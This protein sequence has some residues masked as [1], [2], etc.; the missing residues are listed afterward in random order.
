MTRLPALHLLICPLLHSGHVEEVQ[1]LLESGADPT[2]RD[3][4]GRVP[5]QLA[6]QRAAR[7]AMRRFMSAHP[8]RWDWRAA[9]VPSA[10]T[11]EM[12]AAQAAKQVKE[13]V[14]RPG[15][16]CRGRVEAPK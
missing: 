2:A 8:D 3:E 1:Q 14:M 5:Y 12:E 13:G 7:D 15:W 9:H 16:P 11:E 10:L 6:G 4:R